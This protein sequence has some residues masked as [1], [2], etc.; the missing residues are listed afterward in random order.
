MTNHYLSILSNYTNSPYWRGYSAAAF[1]VFLSFMEPVWPF[2]FLAFL[3]V[4]GDLITGI[5]AAKKRGDKIVSRGIYRTLEKFALYFIV[6][7][8]A[9]KMRIT[10]FPPVPITHVVAFGIC[11]TEFFS[12]AENVETVTGVNI[13]KRMKSIIPGLTAEDKKPK[14]KAPKKDLDA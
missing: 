14:T 7:T 13:I 6:I 12:L 3:L 1:G 10:F 5:R 8:V 4:V 9:E 2:V 11:L